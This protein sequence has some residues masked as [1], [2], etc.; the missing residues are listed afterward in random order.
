MHKAVVNSQ[1]P[2]GQL[3]FLGKGIYNIL[4]H[5][6]LYGIIVLAVRTIFD[7]GII[8]TGSQNKVIEAIG[9]CFFVEYGKI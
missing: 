9:G 3:G 5:R 8:V 4:S 7:P 2:H 1:M 6:T